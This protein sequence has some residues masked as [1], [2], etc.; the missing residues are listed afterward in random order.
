MKPIANI[1]RLGCLL[2]MV[3]VFAGVGPA[4]A[5]Q[6]PVK[7]GDVNKD[8]ATLRAFVEYAK[9]QLDDISDAAELAVLW[10]SM[11]LEGDWK[12]G[13]TYLVVLNGRGSVLFHADQPDAEGKTL[14]GIVD[15]R[16]D[17]I[18]KNILAEAAAGGG[19]FG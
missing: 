2:G 13:N 19:F 18:G 6:A 9:T 12:S 5:Q 4:I 3:N 1:V 7:A 14:R 15:A 8:P 17:S 11:R 16:S 10:G